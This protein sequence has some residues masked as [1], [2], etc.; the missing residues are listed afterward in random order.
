MTSTAVGKTMLELEYDLK[1]KPHTEFPFKLVKHLTE[2]FNLTG[3][4]LD[5]ACGRGEHAAA[6]DQLGL[7]V[8]CVDMSP[9]AAQFLNKRDTNL[10]IADL[11]TE[12]I[13]YEDGRFDVVFCKSF[14]EHVNADRLMGEMWRVLKPGGK[15]IVL[16]LDWWHTFRMH[17][18]DHTHGYG[19]PWMKHSLDL[20]IKNYGFEEVVSEKFYYLTMTWRY[21]WT[22]F[23][24]FLI[25][26][27]PY[28]YTDNF[29]NPVWKLVRFSNEV[30]LLGYGK[31]GSA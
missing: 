10:R 11:L 19:S 25:R 26:R 5:I 2:R 31:K 27:F 15:L 23:I 30:Q 18:I 3:S 28:P 13:P 9:A 1:D 7:D 29:T 4:V 17:Y 14:I 20:I 22:K 12:P 16:T 21:P 6:F 8:W 24:C